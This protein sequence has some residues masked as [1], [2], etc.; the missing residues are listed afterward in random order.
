MTIW[1]VI[2]FIIFAFVILLGFSVA[3]RK[4]DILT[5]YWIIL[6]IIFGIPLLLFSIFI[7]YFVLFVPYF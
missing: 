3:K 7:F 2:N 6:M 1:S 4:S 5:K